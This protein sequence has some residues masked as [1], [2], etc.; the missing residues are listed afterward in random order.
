MKET[1]RYLVSGRV[2]GVGFRFF[3]Q[4]EADRLGITGYVRN[5]PDGR[6]EVVATGSHEQLAQFRSQLE[7]GPRFSSVSW[8][9]EEEAGAD[10]LYDSGFH[11]A[12]GG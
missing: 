12:H 1:R 11:I 4:H 9:L 7:K 5:L 8:V 6:V 3:A 2:Q 10:A